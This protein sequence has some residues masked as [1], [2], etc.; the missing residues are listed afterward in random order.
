MCSSNDCIIKRLHLQY[1][2]YSFYFDPVLFPVINGSVILREK[3]ISL[4]QTTIVMR[5]M[6]THCSSF[7]QRRYTK[8]IRFKSQ[9]N[10]LRNTNIIMIHLNKNLFDAI[11]ST[12]ITMKIKCR[13]RTSSTSENHHRWFDNIYLLKTMSDIREKRTNVPL[14]FFFSSFMRG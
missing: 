11:Q 10:I 9:R 6:F 13:E 5:T 1:G 3:R 4:P 2:C 8:I 7:K 12:M 14:F